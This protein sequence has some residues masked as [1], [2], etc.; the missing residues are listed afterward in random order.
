MKK[1]FLL[2]LFLSLA[3]C[4]L[5]QYSQKE[6]TDN[7]LFSIETTSCYGK[8][9]ELEIVIRG[10]GNAFYIGKKNVDKIGKFEFQLTKEE[11]AE[12]LD[13][14]NNAKFWE[15]Q[16]EYSAKVTDLPTIFISCTYNGKSKRI[17]DYYGAPN[18]LKKLE[19]KIIKYKDKIVVK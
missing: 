8:C 13:A 4:S 15:M 5:L 2:I 6:D 19:E 18:S 7:L 9:P 3:G 1:I 11:I 12:L 14:F 17:K 16:D 10:N